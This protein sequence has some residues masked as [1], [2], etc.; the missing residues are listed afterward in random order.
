MKPIE[1]LREKL[2][3][4]KLISTNN[5]PGVPGTRLINFSKTKGYVELGQFSVFHP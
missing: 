5:F 1:N 2:V 3:E 4:K